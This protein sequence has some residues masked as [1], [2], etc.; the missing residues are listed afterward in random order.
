MHLTERFARVTGTVTETGAFIDSICDHCGDVAIYLGL[1]WRAVT[2]GAR[3]QIILVF[4]IM[5]GSLFGSLV[6][7]QANS[8][9]IDLKD[10]G[11]ATRFERL[12]ILFIGC[13]VNRVEWVLWVL[14]LLSNVSACQRLLSVLSPKAKVK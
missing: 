5:F 1:T 4:V 12:L 3:V 9:R 13:I 6:R 10:V 14:A 8:L 11:L 2:I 7:A